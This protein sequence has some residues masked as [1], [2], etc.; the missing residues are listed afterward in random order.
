ME[1]GHCR[2]RRH[3][4]DSRTAGIGDVIRPPKNSSDVDA[5]GLCFVRLSVFPPS[6]RDNRFRIDSRR[7]PLCLF[8]GTEAQTKQYRQSDH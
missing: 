5:T 7:N 6:S 1:T 8:K 4:M 3:R 2:L